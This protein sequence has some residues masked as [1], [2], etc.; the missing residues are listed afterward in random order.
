MKI[1]TTI[2]SVDAYDEQSTLIILTNKENLAW[3][4][5]FLDENSIQFLK[6]TLES[7]SS[8]CELVQNGQWIFIDCLADKKNKFQEQEAVRRAG[9]T[10]LGRLKHYNI[11]EATLLDYSQKEQ[12]FFFAEGLCLA[13]YQ[14][15]KYFTN[16]KPNRSSFQTLSIHTH[17]LSADLVQTLAV[18]VDATCETRDLVNE[19]LSYLTAVQLSKEIV[20]LGEKSGFCTKVFHKEEIEELGMG[21]LLAVNKGSVQP[22]TFSVLE[23]KPENAQNEQP[24]VLVGKGVVY[25]TGGL[26]LK[27]TPNSM[28][29]MKCDMGG[30]AAVIGA[31]YAV[32]GLKLPVHL[33]VLVPSSD[34]RPGLDA[35]VPGDVV[36]MLSGST[37]EVLNTD[38][39]GRMLL[40][41]ALHYA[42]QYDP[43]LVMDFATLTGAAA[44]A[45][46]GHAMALMGT[47]EKTYKEQVKQA[48]FETYERLVEFPLWDEYGD[49]MKS[50]IADLKNI[51]SGGAGAITAGKFLEHFTDYEWLHF[52]IAGPAY[53]HKE[54]AYKTK[55]GTGAGMRL[56]VEFFRN[57]VN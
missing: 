23:W 33:I 42:K 46:G 1:S 54:D 39:E 32:A 43:M 10:R 48:G 29:F 15:L 24:I 9:A 49:Q 16:V 40:A 6:Q 36:T 52:D 57:F 41:D 2:K 35:Y 56:L 34:N 44:R 27:P 21:G 18:I 12:A 26:S 19:P 22:P 17:A 50:D 38:A 28:D 37:V 4:N 25:D 51:G 20:R 53:M 47:A 14:F 31:M 13:N 7:G 5:E 45:L 55:G 8:Y 11:K 3:A 30:A